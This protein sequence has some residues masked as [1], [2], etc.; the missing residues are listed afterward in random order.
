M[1]SSRSGAINVMFHPKPAKASEQEKKEHEQLREDAESLSKD[2][3]SMA[4][5][6]SMR[7][8]KAS[9]DAEPLARLVAQVK[10]PRILRLLN[11]SVDLRTAM[12]GGYAAIYRTCDSVRGV[13]DRRLEV[14]ILGMD[15]N[16]KP[17]ASAAFR[18]LRTGNIHRLRWFHLVDMPDNGTAEKP[19]LSL[20]RMGADGA[21]YAMARAT[22]RA[23]SIITL[24][25][26]DSVATAALFF[27]T[28]VDTFS[29]FL[30]LGVAWP[31]LNE[32]FAA[33]IRLMS[34]PARR[35]NDG[36]SV[37]SGIDLDV[38]WLNEP[39]AFN[40]KVE[41]AVQIALAGGS[42]RRRPHGTGRGQRKRGRRSGRLAG[43]SAAGEEG[44]SE[45]EE[46]EDSTSSTEKECVG[47]MMTQHEELGE[48][49]A[50]SD[51]DSPGEES[52]NDESSGEESAS[53]GEESDSLSSAGKEYVRDI[54]AQH[55][56][57][58]EDEAESEDDAVGYLGEA[59]EASSD[60]GED[61]QQVEH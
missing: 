37:A 38:S 51:D 26:P 49:E 6:E 4:L 47:D 55:E 54:M 48:D 29:E 14:M 18:V 21:K 5:I 17:V 24:S 45:G 3:T 41:R 58:G 56:E 40:R 53:E 25:F 39:T 10:D 33:I 60:E 57:L 15:A 30:D 23:A 7:V 16:P 22:A 2:S 42:K 52:A 59:G 44:T 11:A 34:K 9:G 20:Q 31:A 27:P 36:G 35:L 50:E 13:L 46:S 61:D 28:L 12:Q 1:A 43:N 32:W 8:I 19:L